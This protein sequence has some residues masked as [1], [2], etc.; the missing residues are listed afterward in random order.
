MLGESESLLFMTPVYPDGVGSATRGVAATFAVCLL[1]R[2]GLRVTASVSRALLL[3]LR[4]VGTSG[5]LPHHLAD[6][7]RGQDSTFRPH[8]C[9]RHAER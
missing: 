3:P 5:Q 2:A 1:P 4:T 8:P 6:S 9:R 7:V